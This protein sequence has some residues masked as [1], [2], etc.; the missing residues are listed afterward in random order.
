MTDASIQILSGQ[1]FSVGSGQ[2][3]VRQATADHRS[4][5]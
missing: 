4:V 3:V 2:A 5:G 1:R